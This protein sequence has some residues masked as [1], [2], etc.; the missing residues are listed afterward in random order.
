MKLLATLQTRWHSVSP[1]EQRLVMLAGVLV[2]LAL[3]WWLALAP[4]LAVLKAAP[5]QHRTLDAQLQHMQRLQAQAKA[6]QAQPALSADQARQALD[7]ALAPLG[8]DAQMTM[9]FDRATVTLKAVGAG[10][11]AQWLA[12]V[13]QN[14]HTAPVEAHLVRNPAGSWDGTLVLNLGARP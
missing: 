6:L 11:L 4:A 9:Q 14:A 12:T 8:S 5:A 2:S 1:R 13:R 10:A 3:L 7:A